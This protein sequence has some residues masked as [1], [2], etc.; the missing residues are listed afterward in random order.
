MG[1]VYPT[2]KGE[3]T[4]DAGG[5]LEVRSDTA[6]KIY[7][8]VS[9]TNHPDS[10]NL[11]TTTTAGVQYVSDAFSINTPIRIEAGASEVN[12]T[13][14][15]LTNVGIKSGSTVT[16]AE[17]SDGVINK[18][19]LTLT[20][21]PITITDDAGVAQ[22]GGAGKIYD[23]PEGAIS[24]VGC[25]VAGNLTLGTTGTIINAFTSNV[26]LG[27]ATATTGATLTGTEA[28]IMASVANGTAATKV[29]AVG[30]TSASMT[31][32]NGTATAKD[33]YLNV[34]VADDVTH[35]SGTGTFTG[36]ITML[37]TNVGD[38]A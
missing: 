18:T 6:C 19:V 15:T 31:L 11:L 17:Y 20:A 34:V 27:T 7:Q 16:A 22:Y 8:K 3:F 30:A 9:Y 38:I 13:Y 1:K 37:W 26:A 25:V 4:V 29:A 23:L 2:G 5:R 12:Y 33:V 36:T 14:G 28:D 24:V 32:L 21:T 35:T 10:W